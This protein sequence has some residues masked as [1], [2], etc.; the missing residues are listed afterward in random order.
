MR[1]YA[2]LCEPSFNLRFNLDRVLFKAPPWHQVGSS[3][4]A[5]SGP[6]P[7]SITFNRKSEKNLNNLTWPVIDS[8]GEESARAEEE[9]MENFSFCSTL[10]SCIAR[11][12]EGVLAVHKMPTLTLLGGQSWPWPPGCIHTYRQRI[13]SIFSV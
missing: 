7:P 10:E 13:N 2:N 8:V 3:Q 9:T 1:H 5:G 12:F 11:D 4:A 6:L